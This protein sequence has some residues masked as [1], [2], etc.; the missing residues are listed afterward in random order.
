M[1]NSGKRGLFLVSRLTILTK[2]KAQVTMESM[3]QDLERRIVASPPGLCP[4]D[5]TR[6]FIKMCLAQ[7]C[8]KCVPCRVGLRQLA[9][10]FD[11]V[12]DGEATE[13]TVENIKLTAE[14]IYYSADCAIGYEAAKL[15]LKS[16]DGCIDDF[17]SHIHNGFCSCNSN[18]PVSCVKSCP[19]G[20]DIPGYIALVQQKRYAD[21]VRLIR[22]DNPM[23]TTCAYICEHPCENRCKRTII[24]APVNIRGL[25]KMAVD[26]AGIV[27]VPECEPA[28]GK[29]VAIIGGGPGGLSAAYYLALMGHKVTIFEQR[30]QLGGMLRYGIPNYRFPRKKLDEEI[31]SILST[32][33]EVKKNISVGKDISFDDITEEYDATYISIGAHADKKMGIEGE[34]AKSGITSAVE[35]L[36]AIGDGDMPD[37]TGKRV[38]VIGGGNVAMDVARSSIRLGASKVSIVYRR[39]KA[40]M[41]A[42][43]EEVVGAEAEGCDVLELMSPVRIKKDEEGN[44]IGLVVKP[45]M[46]SKVSH[47]R[48]APKA[49]SK[50]EVL[51][52]SDLIVVAI[53]Q[54][55]E[56][57][58][59]EEHGIKVQRGVISALNTGNI[60]P[61]EGEMSE[62]VFAG[63]DC[64]TGPA[65]VIKAIAAGKVAA[66]NIDEYLGFN[67]EITCDVEIPYASNEDKVACGRVEVAL[68]EAAERKNDFEPI[69]YGFTCEEACQEAGRCLRC[70]HFGFGA[71][72]GGREEQW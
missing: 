55:I 41:T 13:E 29:K 65:T 43:E 42:L 33:I 23:P 37:Y 27:P 17:E 70:D 67:H 10:L 35:M 72:R 45:Q 46:I 4:V 61:Q 25:K 69:E 9:R 3:Y 18:Q 49:A 24:D 5:L 60:T 57:K 28:T 30:K 64:V 53:G 2:D 38:I 34:D 7:S 11:N 1:L 47:G 63:G 56:T 44:A 36:R 52:E 26:N 54:G 15:A 19:A 6:S 58:S 14:G 71:F 66:A 68:R 59:F 62:G 22:R 50:D 48:P 12:L 39:R 21:A 32:G 16:V 51:L 20:V 31:D 8:G 40:D